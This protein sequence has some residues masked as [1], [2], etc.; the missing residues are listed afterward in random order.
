MSTRGMNAKLLYE[1]IGP[2]ET[3]VELFTRQLICL[4]ASQSFVK[5]R[6]I[7]WMMTKT[8]PSKRSRTYGFSRKD[9]HFQ[10][11]HRTAP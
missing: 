8:W 11:V 10:H 6:P 1:K 4:F 9:T 5:E 2:N 7:P 3:E